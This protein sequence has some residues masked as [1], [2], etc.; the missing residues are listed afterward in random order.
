MMGTLAAALAGEKIRTP[1]DRYRADVEG[2]IRAV[3]GVLRITD[4]RVRYTLAIPPRE[5]GRRPPLLRK[6]PG[7]LPGRAE[8]IRVHP[9]RP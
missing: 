4:I 9:H 7:E 2:H 3:G 6:L 1:A 5:R 8:R